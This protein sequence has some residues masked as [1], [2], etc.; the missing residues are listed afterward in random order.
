MTTGYQEEPGGMERF[1]CW[2]EPAGRGCAI[3]RAARYDRELSA[4]LHQQEMADAAAQ[5]AA[6]Q[7]G[8]Q[9]AVNEAT[10]SQISAVASLMIPAIA[11]VGI[12]IGGYL[13]YRKRRQQPPDPYDELSDAEL[14]ARIAAL[15][16]EA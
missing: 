2:L 1:L 8:Y 4:I 12:G 14:E 7:Q 9:Q 6:A 13:W 5:A 16:Q 3:Y 10:R 11:I 15:S